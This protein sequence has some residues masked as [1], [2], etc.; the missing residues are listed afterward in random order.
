MIEC[1]EILIEL[2]AWKDFVIVDIFFKIRGINENWTKP[3]KNSN[4]I[5]C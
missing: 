4:W 5:N 2:I 1:L 3:F